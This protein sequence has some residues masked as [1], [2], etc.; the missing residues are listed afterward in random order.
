MRRG[1]T[2]IELL[3]TMT[4]AAI[5]AAAILGTASSA[6]ESS[7][8]LVKYALG[9]VILMDHY[10]VLLSHRHPLKGGE[11]AGNYSGKRDSNS[12]PF[13]QDHSTINIFLKGYAIGGLI[14]GY[15]LYLCSFRVNFGWGAFYHPRIG[16]CF[17]MLGILALIVFFSAAVG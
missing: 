4:I 8:S 15:G 7:R 13:V 3:I 1:V 9:N 2:I 11:N 12:E 16:G 5:I 10:I 6:I 14:I 17:V